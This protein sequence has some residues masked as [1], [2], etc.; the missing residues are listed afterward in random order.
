MINWELPH[1]TIACPH[2]G[3]RDT[4]LTLEL[5][6]LIRYACQS[7]RKSFAAHGNR[8][9]VRSRPKSTA[10]DETPGRV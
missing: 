2:C 10:I 8:V 3:S 4:R 1:E 9:S 7:C 5:L 6:G